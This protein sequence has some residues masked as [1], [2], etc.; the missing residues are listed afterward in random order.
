MSKFS[1]KK[2][3]KEDLDPI[4]KKRQLNNGKSK[5]IEEQPDGFDDDEIKDMK[6]DEPKL[7]FD[8]FVD[9]FRE[10]K[11]A[12]M[13]QKAIQKDNSKLQLANRD[14]KL[15][16]T[17]LKFTK[18]NEDRFENHFN[19]LSKDILK[20]TELVSEKAPTLETKKITG[21]FSYAFEEES[22]DENLLF[23]EQEKLNNQVKYKEY[24]LKSI[25][26]QKGKLYSDSNGEVWV[27]DTNLEENPSFKKG[28][29]TAYNIHQVL[30]TRVAELDISEDRPFKDGIFR[31]MQSYFDIGYTDA[32]EAHLV[33]VR[34]GLKF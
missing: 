22:E 8:K 9:I 28:I 5:Q 29:D 10:G 4:I 20:K 25:L 18:K 33:S 26:K 13:K 31:L 34:L 19:L 30:Q 11:V 2:K 15:S 23:T 17:P 16:Y 12:K 3:D 14:M 6:F 21:D 24:K 27:A 1:Y 32:N 7:K